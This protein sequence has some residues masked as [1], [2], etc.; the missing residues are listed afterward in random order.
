MKD[1][2]YENEQWTQLPA[3][4]K[5][6]PLFTRHFDFTSVFL[7]YLWA[8]ILKFLFKSYIQLKV[9]GDFKQLYKNYPRLLVVSNHSSHLDAVSI[10][11]AVPFKYWR[12]LYIAA[13]KDYFFGNSVFTFF[14]KHCLGAIPI[15]R[16]KNKAESVKL[17]LNL[18]T[19]LD[20][21][22]LI[23][24]PEGTRS[25][26]GY[27]HSFKRGVS[28]FAE[29]TQTPILFLYLDGPRTLWPKGQFFSK[30]GKMT[31]HVGP[32]SPPSD[33]DS[34]YLRYQK[35]VTTINPEAYKTEDL[36][37]GGEDFLDA[38]H[39]PAK[40]SNDASGKNLSS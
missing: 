28:L 12:D 2:D 23:I 14:S 6:L 34:L 19:K 35:W 33:T 11:A 38:S 24:F 9:E 32:V 3:H 22:W 27:I 25:P 30:P 18:L 7:R 40:T 10:T 29:Q 20:R 31:V 39:F 15:D 8:F 5:H 16:K 21:C 36:L 37:E 17:C 4:M 26:D 1:W 13:A